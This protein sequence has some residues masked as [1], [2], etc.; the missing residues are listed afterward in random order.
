MASAIETWLYGSDRPHGIVS[1]HVS[2]G[3]IV[4][5]V[6]P[7]PWDAREVVTDA[8]FE[9]AVLRYVQSHSDLS[10]DDV[11]LPWDII[12]FDSYELADGRWE[13]VVCCS[14]LEV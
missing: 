3:Q 10:P 9:A 13:F 11:E 14:A 8:T 1:F 5:A 12:G 6:A 2:P 7:Y 4:I